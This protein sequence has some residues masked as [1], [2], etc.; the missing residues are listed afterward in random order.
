MSPACSGNVDNAIMRTDPESPPNPPNPANF[1]LA[2]GSGDPGGL[3]CGANVAVG[4]ETILVAIVDVFV[5][6]GEH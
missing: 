6:S 5:V 1:R 3:T 4:V 2:L